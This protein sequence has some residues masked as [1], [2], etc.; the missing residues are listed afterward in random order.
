MATWRASRPTNFVVG[1]PQGEGVVAG[2]NEVDDVEDG[3]S[4]CAMQRRG[5]GSGG[6][7]QWR[8]GEE[9]RRNG[10]ERSGGAV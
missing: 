3:M 2:G 1:R 8:G 5:G 9:P 7:V 4:G 10:E 6:A